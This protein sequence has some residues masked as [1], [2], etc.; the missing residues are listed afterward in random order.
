MQ[1]VKV[2]SVDMCKPKS[3]G[4]VYTA[5]PLKVGQTVVLKHQ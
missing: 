4:Q 1:E 2:K 3:D 5:W